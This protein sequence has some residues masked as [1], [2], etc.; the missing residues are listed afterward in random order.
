MHA[1]IPLLFILQVQEPEP[2]K[3]APDQTVV[4]TASPLKPDEDRK[5]TR[6]NSSH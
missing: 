3:P 5:S 4:I 2:R 6:L 1:L